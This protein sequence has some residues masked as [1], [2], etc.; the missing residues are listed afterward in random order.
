MINISLGTMRFF[1]LL[2]IISSY[3]IAIKKIDV[4]SDIFFYTIM[5]AN[6]M[7]ISF[8]VIDE[9]NNFLSRK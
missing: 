3:F 7:V 9:I 2:S 8:W 4:P 1:G 5:T 6:V